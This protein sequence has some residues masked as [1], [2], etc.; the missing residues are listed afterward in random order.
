MGKGSLCL[1]YCCCEANGG[2]CLYLTFKNSTNVR[3]KGVAVPVYLPRNAMERFAAEVE[4]LIHG[5][6]REVHKD[7]KASL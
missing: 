5:P 2:Q 4:K 3:E 7:T 1:S 6:L